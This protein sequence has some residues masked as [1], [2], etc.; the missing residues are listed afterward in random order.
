[1]SNAV[2]HD[3]IDWLPTGYR[4]R[5]RREE[6][7]KYTHVLDARYAPRLYATPDECFGGSSEWRGDGSR[8][9]PQST[10][11]VH[12]ITQ[13]P[14]TAM[15]RSARLANSL[16]LL[17]CFWLSKL[18]LPRGVVPSLEDEEGSERDPRLTLRNDVPTLL[19]TGEQGRSVAVSMENTEEEGLRLTLATAADPL[20]SERR[21]AERRAT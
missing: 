2:P 11:A 8:S 9:L 20:D 21:A 19:C 13:P 6:K 14:Q 16:Q 17:R 10:P 18:H 3:R 15:E 7:R 4:L 1:M 5:A 12:S